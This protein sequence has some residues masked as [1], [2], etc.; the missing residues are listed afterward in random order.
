MLMHIINVCVDYYMPEMN[1]LQEVLYWDSFVPRTNNQLTF[2]YY[3]S[4]T[5]YPC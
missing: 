3:Y 4:S 2:E 5:T 1:I